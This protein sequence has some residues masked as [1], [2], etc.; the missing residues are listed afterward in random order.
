[1]IYSA[2]NVLSDP[3]NPGSADFN[4][5]T[6]S[7]ALKNVFNKALYKINYTMDFIDSSSGNSGKY[8]KLVNTATFNDQTG[9]LGSCDSLACD[10]CF[11]PYDTD[12][13]K[14]K[15]SYFI[16]ESTCRAT[17]T[18][19]TFLQSPA[20]TSTQPTINFAPFTT[21]TNTGTI[22]FFI[23][24]FGFSTSPTSNM[25][26]YSSN[27]KLKYSTTAGA[28]YGLSLIYIAG[29][30]NI[31]ATDSSFRDRFGQWTYIHLAYCDKSLPGSYPAMINFMIN[32]S[33][34]KI[35]GSSPVGY[36]INLFQIPN[37]TYA[38][39]SSIRAYNTYMINSYAY[40]LNRW[41][42]TRIIPVYSYIPPG[43]SSTNC[44]NPGTET[45]TPV[46]PDAYKCIT[47]YDTFFDTTAKCKVPAP[48]SY[49]TNPSPNL[50]LG[51]NYFDTTTCN[52]CPYTTVSST[53]KYRCSTT[54]SSGTASDLSCACEMKESSLSMIMKNSNQN[55]CK[56]NINLNFITLITYYLEFDYINYSRVNLVTMTNIAVAKST[57]KYTMQF[58]MFVNNYVGNNF[59]GV[60][61][62]W[63]MHNKIVISYN[64]GTNYNFIC[65]PFWDS[66][67]IGTYTLN[68]NFSTALTNINKWNFIS[69]A[70]DNT[71]VKQFYSMTDLVSATS[72]TISGASP[73][74]I[75]LTTTK[76]TFQDDSS[77]DYGVLFF[78]QI[79]LWIDAY[80]SAGFLSR[81]NIQTYTLFSNLMHLFDP[82]FKDADGSTQKFYDLTNISPT[83]TPT[84]TASLG[85]NVVDDSL[86]STLSLSDENGQYYDLATLSNIRN[87]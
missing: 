74:L 6:G 86:Y 25:I 53:K 14:C 42:D 75:P 82:L 11:G 13:W 16:T 4:V 50:Y 44:F 67:N 84:Y 12:C 7:I 60:T 73:N 33:N 80:T 18:G 78:R 46:F 76:F 29:V 5:N 37:S 10:R 64:S 2:R 71:V 38:L 43:S 8:L 40:I 56:S 72:Q 32:D 49:P 22:S 66:A 31:I 26:F 21:I 39:F 62:T 41:F 34:I 85:V 79:R 47:D 63:D 55:V 52:E 48:S 17:S 87:N 70:V 65:Y 15:S 51:Y 19:K 9:S 58:W 45:S 35:T 28:S 24:L 23:K 59:G 27:L 69:C 3:L 61:F 57:N 30:D 54:C 83:V 68:Y 1:L 81:V 20:I 36:S 77:L